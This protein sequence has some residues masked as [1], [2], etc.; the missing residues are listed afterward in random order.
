M[1]FAPVTAA[2]CLAASASLHAAPPA[3]ATPAPNQMDAATLGQ[4]DGVLTL[5]AK[6][7]PANQASYDRYRT[8]MIVFGEGTPYEMR[9]PGSDSPAY[10]QAYAAMH[11][12]AGRASPEEQAAQCRR[13]IGA[14][15]ADKSQ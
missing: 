1:K 10:K 8:E 6:V 9:V 12:A 2:L 7:D 5:C 11:E 15:V 14:D 4:L 13:T 3:S